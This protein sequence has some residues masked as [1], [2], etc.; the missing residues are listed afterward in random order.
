MS[1]TGKNFLL[2]CFVTITVYMLAGCA[3]PGSTAP[4]A[5]AKRASAAEPAEA[6]AETAAEE[7][8]ESTVSKADASETAKTIPLDESKQPA[9][10]TPDIVGISK[11][12][13]AYPRV[14]WRSRTDSYEIYVGKLLNANYSIDKKQLTVRTDRPDNNNLIC[15]YSLDGK[16]DIKAPEGE[17][18]TAK[19]CQTLV[20]QL[21]KMLNQ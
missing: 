11:R 12:L 7:P 17:T 3:A 2:L 6:A 9:A 4:E 5:A 21:D 15:T 8:K 18:A 10:N 16:L 20:S 13:S 1:Q 19:Q 14:L